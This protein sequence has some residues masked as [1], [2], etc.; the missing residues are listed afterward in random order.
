MLYDIYIDKFVLKQC[1]SKSKSTNTPIE[2]LT[3]TETDINKIHSQHTHCQPLSSSNST[4]INHDPIDPHTHSRSNSI[5]NMSTSSK[6]DRLSFSETQL[7]S[8]TSFLL[9]RAHAI[10]LDNHVDT[11]FSMEA[12]EHGFRG[13]GGKQDDITIILVQFQQKKVH[14]KLKHK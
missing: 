3:M 8:L 9:S 4:V 10:S 7:H 5:S 14:N 12:R 13:I 1:Q 11:P 2:H 6:C